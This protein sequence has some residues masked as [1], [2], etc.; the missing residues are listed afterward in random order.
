MFVFQLKWMPCSSHKVA[1]AC[2]GMSLWKS[3]GG[4]YILRSDEVLAVI[5]AKRC[6]PNWIWTLSQGVA[7][8]IWQLSILRESQPLGWKVAGHED[9]RIWATWETSL[10]LG[11]TQAILSL[12]V[13]VRWLLAFVDI[14]PIPK[15]RLYAEVSFVLHKGTTGLA[16]S[17]PQPATVTSWNQTSNP[18]KCFE[19]DVHWFPIRI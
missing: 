16:M 12:K 6:S 10:G 3:L 11:H 1:T 9:L 13:R 18:K 15:L 17:Y 2:C 8:C 19:Y 14:L 7:Q 5:E 4:D